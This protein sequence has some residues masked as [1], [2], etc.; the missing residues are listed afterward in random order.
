MSLN[1]VPATVTQPKMNETRLMATFIIFPL[2]C[3]LSWI[4][5]RSIHLFISIIVIQYHRAALRHKCTVIRH[6]KCFLVSKSM[7]SKSIATAQGSP[8]AGGAIEGKLKSRAGPRRSRALAT[9]LYWRYRQRNPRRSSWTLQWLLG[10]RRQLSLPA[11]RRTGDGKG[12]SCCS[13]CTLNPR[14][15]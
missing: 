13:D 4:L 8:W 12:A 5:F 3:F 11:C 7:S 10:E 2:S 14:C 9:G 6:L 15:R 1:S